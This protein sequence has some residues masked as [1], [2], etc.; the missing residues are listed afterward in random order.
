M[1]LTVLSIG[2][3]FYISM[4][5]I[6]VACENFG[7][8]W[9]EHYVH[10]IQPDWLLHEPLGQVVQIWPLRRRVFLSFTIVLEVCRM[11]RIFCIGILV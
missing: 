3:P 5:K 6:A 7:H 8:C 2:P 1:E 4:E 10:T 9:I 11:V